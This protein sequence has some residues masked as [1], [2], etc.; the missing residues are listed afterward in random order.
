MQI[1]SKGRLWLQRSYK[2]HSQLC[3]KFGGIDRNTSSVQKVDV[4]ICQENVHARQILKQLMKIYCRERSKER[5]GEDNCNREIRG[6]IDG[7]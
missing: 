5:G 2:F 6:G 7:L 4:T 3:A 1:L